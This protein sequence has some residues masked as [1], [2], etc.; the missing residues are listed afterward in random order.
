MIR[1]AA[2]NSLWE[3]ESFTQPP[4]KRTKTYRHRAPIVCAQWVSDACFLGKAN[5]GTRP[6][7]PKAH[8]TKTHMNT[9]RHRDT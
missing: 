4:I 1:E 7:T 9:N 6:H 5:P 2:E 8:V 3:V